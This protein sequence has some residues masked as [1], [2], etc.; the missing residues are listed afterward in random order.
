MRNLLICIPQ[1]STSVQEIRPSVIQE[2][3]RQAAYL[4]SIHTAIIRVWR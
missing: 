4:A 3:G 1:I 2:V